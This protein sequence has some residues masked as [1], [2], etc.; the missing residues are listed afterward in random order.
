MAQGLVQAELSR[1]RRHGAMGQLGPLSLE[2]FGDRGWEQAG[3][4]A[5]L[6]G[7]VSYGAPLDQVYRDATVVMNVTSAQMPEGVNQRVFDV[8]QCGAFLLSD[9]QAE[10]ADYFDLDREMAVFTANDALAEVAAHWLRRPLDRR[11]MVERAQRRIEAEH[12]FVHRLSKLVDQLRR[13]HG[14]MRFRGAAA[15]SPGKSPSR[16]HAA[17]PKARA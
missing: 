5:R 10:L 2:I 17:Q 4:A 12:L 13:D 15:V 14:P 3:T 1:Q 11:A 7:Q 6:F 9:C 16:V 8:P